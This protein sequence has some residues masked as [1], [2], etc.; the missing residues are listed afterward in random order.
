LFLSC[1]EEGKGKQE[2]GIVLARHNP[3]RVSGKKKYNLKK[4][5]Q[6][7]IRYHVEILFFLLQCY[8]K[9]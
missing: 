5:K 4:N 1:K 3:N 2:M 8:R 7:N 9:L 6:E